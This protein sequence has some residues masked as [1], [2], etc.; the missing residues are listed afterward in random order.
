MIRLLAL[1][2]IVIGVLLTQTTTVYAAHY[3]VILL[4]GQSNM[5][6]NGPKLNDLTA[7]QQ[8]PQ[9]DVWI[10]GGNGPNSG[11]LQPGFG[12]PYGPE[13]T[14]GRTIADGLPHENFALI[15]FSQGGTHLYGDWDPIT[16]SVYNKFKAI[17]GFGLEALTKAGHTYEI[18]GMLW[19]QGERDAA[20]GRTTAEYEADLNDFIADIRSRYGAHV[21]FFISR[22][23]ILQTGREPGLH[24]IRA[25]QENVAASDSNAY[26]IDTDSF[27]IAGDDIHFTGTGLVSLGNAF[28][29]SYLNSLPVDSAAP[30]IDTLSPANGGLAVEPT[31]NLSITFNE[32]VVF[33]TGHITLR[34]A[35]GALIE[36]YDV[37]SPP[38][39]LMLSGS[40]ITI[41]PSSLLSASTGYTIEIDSTAIEDNAGNSFIGIS[42]DS[43]WAFTTS[44]GDNTA[45]TISS[46]S[47]AHNASDFKVNEDLIVTFPENIALGTGNINLRYAIGGTL[48]ESYDVAIPSANLS[49]SGGSLTIHPSSDL[50]PSTDYYVEIDATAIDD[51]AGNSFAGFS[52]SGTWAFRTAVPPIDGS[53]I[54]ATGSSGSFNADGTALSTPDKTVDGSGLSNGEHGSTA[55]TY[56][57]TNQWLQ[58]DLNAS[59]TLDSIHVWNFNINEVD[60]YTSNAAIPGDIGSGHWTQL[61]GAP[62]NLPAAGSPNT[63][64]DLAT[65]TSTILPATELRHIRFEAKSNWSGSDFGI[66]EIQFF[67]GAG[68]Q[69]GSLPGIT[70][71]SPANGGMDHPLDGDLSVT[72]S[73]DIVFSSGTITLYQ[74]GGAAVETFNTST[75]GSSLSISGKVL[76]IDPTAELSGGTDYYVEIGNGA[77]EDLDGHAYSG[78]SGDGV[79]SFTSFTPD[80]TAPLIDT[81]Y[82]VNEAGGF[83]AVDSLVIT[84][85]EEVVFGTGDITL[86]L[87]DGTLVESF[88]VAPPAAGLS[89]SGATVTI[90]PTNPLAASTGYYVEI[91]ST[92]ID[93]LSGNSF[94]GISGDGTWSFTSSSATLIDGSGITASASSLSNGNPT[95][96]ELTIDGSGLSGD[97]HG[98]GTQISWM[99]ASNGTEDEEW[100]QWD[101][102]DTYILDSIHVWNYND[103][104]RFDAGINQVDIYVSLLDS[105]GDPE[106]AGAGNWTQIGSDVNL[107]KAPGLSSYTGFDLKA[108]TGI[109]F[110]TAPV[111]WVRFEVDTTHWDGS[112]PGNQLPDA[113]ALAEIQFVGSL[114]TGP[115]E[116]A[117]GLSTLSPA[118]GSSGVGI[119]SNLTITFTEAVAFGTGNITLRQSG[120]ALVESFDVSGPATG[121]SL[122]GASVTLNPA[123]NLSELTSYYVEIDGTAIDDLAGNSFPGFSGNG[124]WSFTTE[125]GDVAPPTISNLSPANGT[126]DVA[127]GGNLSITFSEAVAFGSGSITL[128][129]S[130][131]ALVESFDVSG[132]AAGLSLS[133]ATVTINPASNLADST[134]YYVEIDGSAIED[135]A[136]NRFAGFTGSST[137][138]FTAGIASTTTSAADS[139]AT[140]SN[141]FN[142]DPVGGVGR[143]GNGSLDIRTIV[144]FSVADIVTNQGLSLGDF[145]A[146][147]FELAFSTVNAIT[148]D[149]GQSYVVDYL[150]FR[151]NV[152][153]LGE[154]FLDPFYGTAATSL[155]DTG[156]EDNGDADQSIS[157]SGFILSDVT[158]LDTNDYVVFRIT[159][160]QTTAA[161]LQ[162]LDGFTLSAAAPPNDFNYWISGFSGLGG[163]IGFEDDPDNDRYKSGLENYFGTHPG[164]FSR[165][166]LAGKVIGNTFTFTHPLNDSPASDLTATY[167]WS[168]DLSAFHNDGDSFEGTTVS[169]SPGDPDINGI[170]TVTATITGT[171]TN[172]LFVDLQV[173]Q[174]LP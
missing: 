108:T 134:S 7:A 38:V 83:P 113:A 77:I 78:F 160:N 42:G 152:S 145:A 22:L 102:G 59:Y 81:L 19:T 101:L 163:Q 157:A 25:A 11:A 173:T 131:G 142:A 104:A 118:N 28:G 29:Q 35:G 40:T 86:R 69:G 82:P 12:S 16:G 110:P 91:D 47:P 105:P 84:F 44:A 58:W 10:Y 4:G 68:A 34:Q 150:G 31:T 99:S 33:G 126:S 154:T 141:G 129:Q 114:N 3:K 87:S 66:S 2:P 111:R 153:S 166:I 143:N 80:V 27:Q 8:L 109:T 159:Y 14:F 172:E 112:A 156:V 148:L 132:P 21:S 95:R 89:L 43:T 119:S 85:D 57:V 54:T 70:A 170:V 140:Q 93:D 76:T 32:D 26:L 169:F 107:P 56:G 23:S 171:A 20:H 39:N 125:A 51:Q 135:L 147:E 5:T 30:T 165:G 161:T 46:L 94:L 92:S 67:A 15:K 167:R 117:P 139:I 6:G 146:T 149:S 49:I 120:S 75:P 64:F 62:V 96:A 98:T 74:S 48:V 168:K 164:E 36:S 55:G 121:L 174:N 133:G 1:C 128:R 123:A 17:V 90:D 122:N 100:I 50:I 88:D 136:G 116:T 61:G 97:T 106:G 144:A 124:T 79:W 71:F 103:S 52:G 72:F 138:S 37:A 18:V 130:G 137:W 127:P 73:E 9:E 65:A 24:D 60:I 45:P 115:D 162:R 158:E 53:T 151:S 155:I 63:G 13:V 41:D